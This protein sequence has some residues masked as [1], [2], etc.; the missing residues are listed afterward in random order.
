MGQ[1]WMRNNRALHLSL[2]TCLSGI[3]ST[4]ASSAWAESLLVGFILHLA[5][6]VAHLVGTQ[7]FLNE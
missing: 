7:I 6:G 3:S 5:Q 1:T 2:F 4:K